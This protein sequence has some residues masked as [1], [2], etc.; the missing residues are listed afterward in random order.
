MGISKPSPRKPQEKN[1]FL[2]QEVKLISDELTEASRQ[3][4]K[5]AMDKKLAPATPRRRRGG[6]GP[7]AVGSV[8]G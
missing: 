3:N 4:F 6:A 1:P 8:R 7:T 5:E 2:K